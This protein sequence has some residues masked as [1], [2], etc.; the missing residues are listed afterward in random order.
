MKKILVSL[1]FGASILFGSETSKGAD[2]IESFDNPSSI[3]SWVEGY[4]TTLSHEEFEGDGVLSYSGIY[5]YKTIDYKNN[6]FKLS[7]DNYITLLET[8][9]QN[10]LAWFDIG[11]IKSPGEFGPDLVMAGTLYSPG[12]DLEFAH[13]IRAKG[14]NQNI[15]ANS[16]NLEDFRGI[17][18]HFEI[19]YD[20]DSIGLVTYNGKSDNLE[21]LVY[22][23]RIGS[24]LKFTDMDKF[25]FRAI[26]GWPDIFTVRGYLDNVRFTEVPEPPTAILA[27]ALSGILSLTRRN[28]RKLKRQR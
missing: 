26:G 10:D 6:P 3:N 8:Q 18:Q 17:W 20:G 5:F 21:N 12:R 2:Y 15:G 1:I 13:G 7:W 14:G 9:N 27:G 19:D 23:S 4:S 28:N 16:D 25:G 11:L 22:T 24:N